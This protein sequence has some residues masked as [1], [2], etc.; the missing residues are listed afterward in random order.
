MKKIIFLFC[1]FALLT[2]TA[3]VRIGFHSDVF[4][5]DTA[6]SSLTW[7]AEKAKG[8]HNGSINFSSGQIINNHGNITGTFEIDMTTIQN[9]DLASE[10]GK[11]KLE[12]HLK[13]PD[14]FDV[15][16]F[17]KSKF[18]ITSVTPGKSATDE[19]VTHTVKGMLTIKDKT[20]EIS[21][22]AAIKLDNNGI[23]CIGSAVI[24]RSKFDIKY[25]SK[26]FYPEIGDKVIYDEFTLRFN[27]VANK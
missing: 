23:N 17:P 18:I 21:F 1:A 26:T 11:S 6:K 7:Y 2:L 3:F 22:D 27:V 10:E 20:N 9:K 24:D 12:G 5:V 14:F 25:G 8:K 19:N 16:K 15:V 13:S 4:T